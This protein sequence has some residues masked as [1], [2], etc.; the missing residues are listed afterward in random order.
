MLLLSKFILDNQMYYSKNEQVT[1]ETCDLRNWLNNDFINTAFTNQEQMLLLKTEITT[2]DLDAGT[3]MYSDGSVVTD[4]CFILSFEEIKSL[5][6]EN[7]RKAPISE[8]SNQKQTK[9]F[10]DC[11]SWYIRSGN[12]NQIQLIHIYTLTR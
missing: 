11:G 5:V 9:W 12:C 1:W 4:R 3:I 6:D 8:Y 2:P 10:A 7:E